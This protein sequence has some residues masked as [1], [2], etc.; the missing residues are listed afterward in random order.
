MSTEQRLALIAS[1]VARYLDHPGCNVPA[2]QNAKRRLRWAL[3]QV[4]PVS[5]EKPA[6][7]FACDKNVTSE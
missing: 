5:S 6:H 2:Q 1:E 3:E 4:Q 7:C